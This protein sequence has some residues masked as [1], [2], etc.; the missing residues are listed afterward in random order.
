M[1]PAPERLDD[2]GMAITDPIVDVALA[3]KA[4]CAHLT[5]EEIATA[6]AGAA[7]FLETVGPALVAIAQ[8]L[9]DLQ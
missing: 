4:R 3:V 8:A 1:A 6:A 9:Q 5:L 2:P 7:L